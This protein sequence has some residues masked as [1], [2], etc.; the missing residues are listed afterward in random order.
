MKNHD[1]IDLENITSLFYLLVEEIIETHRK[2]VENMH[3]IILVHVQKMNHQY[4]KL[5]L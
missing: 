2:I 4:S 5:R 3:E 1:R